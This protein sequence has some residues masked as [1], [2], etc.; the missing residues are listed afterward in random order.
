[1]Y[2]QK[3]TKPREHFQDGEPV[4]VLYQGHYNGMLGKF[5]GIRRDPDWADIEEGNG[6]VRPHPFDWIRRID[7]R[8]DEP[9]TGPDR[10]A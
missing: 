2:A 4:L 6:I 3:V 8:F 9:D 7:H 1:M 5:R 10:V